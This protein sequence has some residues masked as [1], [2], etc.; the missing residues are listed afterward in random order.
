MLF[1]TLQQQ[2]IRIHR[3][4]VRADGRDGH[5]PALEWRLCN[6]LDCRAFR[7]SLSQ[8]HREAVAEMNR[9]SCEQAPT[10]QSKA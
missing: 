5:S 7:E 8:R 4:H 1:E 3:A 6:H 2:A 9:R 10:I